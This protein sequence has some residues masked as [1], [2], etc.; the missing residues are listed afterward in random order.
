VRIGATTSLMADRANHLNSSS[1]LRQHAKL[2]LASPVS[3]GRN[4]FTRPRPGADKL[5]RVA[6][7]AD[8][9]LQLCHLASALNRMNDTVATEDQ[10][11]TCCET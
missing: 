7:D 11:Q 5:L 10:K 9:Q 4:V 3:L 8:L 6:R 1:Q 2:S